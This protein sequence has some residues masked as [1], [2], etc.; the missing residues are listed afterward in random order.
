M[1]KEPDKMDQR[2]TIPSA[3]SVS[4]AADDRALIRRLRAGDREALGDLI[5]SYQKRVLSVAYK[6]TGDWHTAQDIAQE[7]FVTLVEKIDSF[8]ME[9]AFFSWIYRVAINRCIDHLRRRQREQAYL[10]VPDAPRAE[11]TSEDLLIKAEMRRRVHTLLGRLPVAY[12]TVL[13]LRDIEGLDT[14]RIA[15]IIDSVPATTR[16]RIFQARKLFRELWEKE[17]N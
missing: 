11:M 17:G 14:E 15:E 4:G 13:V 1:V 16:W 3:A 8:D 5:N 12:R 10:A 9:R 2:A 6:M 7:V